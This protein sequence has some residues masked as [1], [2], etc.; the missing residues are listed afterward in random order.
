MAHLIR[1]MARKETKAAAKGSKK[2]LKGSTK[3]TNSKL[4]FKY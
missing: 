1:T 3:L 2:V 4:M